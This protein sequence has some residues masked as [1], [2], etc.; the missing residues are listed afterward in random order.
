MNKAKGIGNVLERERG[1][2]CCRS[3]FVRVL[4]CIRPNNGDNNSRRIINQKI[5]KRKL[6][7]TNYT[8]SPETTFSETD[9]VKPVNEA[10]TQ[11]KHR[12]ADDIQIE[13]FF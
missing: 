7:C 8:R 4:V 6:K 12:P 3:F 2:S 5:Y 9:Q 11:R 13:F 10:T 1:G